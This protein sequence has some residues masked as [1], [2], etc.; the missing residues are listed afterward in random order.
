MS[1]A[2]SCHEPVAVIASPSGLG[3]SLRRP[4]ER[5]PSDER[6]T[7]SARA[8]EPRTQTV[9]C[10]TRTL[11]SAICTPSRPQ[12]RQRLLNNF[13][14]PINRSR[15]PDFKHNSDPVSASPEPRDMDARGG[16]TCCKAGVWGARCTTG[17]LWELQLS[18]RQGSTANGRN[19]IRTRDGQCSRYFGLCAGRRAPH[20]CR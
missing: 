16:A 9:P 3:V 7:D 5:T 19:A 10:R 13:I 6:T 17:K 15:H 20:R 14:G 4:A 2:K 8:A 12:L 18:K 1:A 11:P